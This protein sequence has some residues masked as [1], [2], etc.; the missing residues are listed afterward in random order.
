MENSNNST[1]AFSHIPISNL[2][3]ESELPSE[4]KETLENLNALVHKTC[5][6]T[7]QANFPSFKE[8]NAQE[9]HSLSSRHITESPKALLQRILA[10]HSDILIYFESID[11]EL[12]TQT[13]KLEL[14]LNLSPRIF[15]DFSSLKK[16]ATKDFT[17]FSY[18]V[19]R[20]QGEHCEILRN[21]LE[22]R[23]NYLQELN[24]AASSIKQ[25]TTPFSTSNQVDLLTDEADIE[26]STDGITDT[27]SSS[28]SSSSP[29]QSIS[30][31]YDIKKT[32]F[33]IQEF[34]G[35]DRTCYL[36]S[37]TLST[38]K[39]IADESMKE[40]QNPSEKEL[41]EDSRDMADSLAEHL[42]ELDG[43][44]TV[45]T[46]IDTYG[47]L[48]S[49]AIIK[50]Q[51]NEITINTFATHPHNIRSDLNLEKP[52]RVQ[53]AGTALIHHLFQKCLIEEKDSIGLFSLPNAC[54][55]YRKMH[56]IQGLP[57]K[58]SEFIPMHISASEISKQKNTL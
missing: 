30:Y 23:V 35:D 19:K 54:E 46:C 32:R 5:H 37:D 41:F 48:Q 40:T 52:N 39:S 15:T 31:E 43:K 49:I 53:G 21:H 55:F 1:S 14:E 4:N 27:E 22:E 8:A 36:L 9:L 18:L 42:T 34:S 44:K 13:K 47:N 12:N 38:W 51:E 10:G 45:I 24:I 56:F 17:L 58:N 28:I 33:Y 11:T 2:N 3:I 50:N 25:R 16:T 57:S 20:S 29:L 26:I 7:I 6:P